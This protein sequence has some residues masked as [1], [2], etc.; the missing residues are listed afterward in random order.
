[1][2]LEKFNLPCSSVWLPWRP[3]LHAL[4]SSSSSPNSEATS[5]NSRSKVD[6]VMHCGRVYI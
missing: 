1:M 5:E 3:G 4:L 2:G 6:F